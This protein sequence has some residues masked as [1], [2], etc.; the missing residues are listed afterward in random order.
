MSP[1]NS[2]R[3]LMSDFFT[4]RSRAYTMAA[5]TV[6][7]TVAA[8][9]KS[10]SITQVTD[11]DIFNV[12]DYSTPAG[13]NPLRVGVISNFTTAF[14]GGTDSYVTMSGNLADEMLASDTFDGRLTINARRSVE[15]NTEMEAVYRN[16]QR[17]RAGGRPR[18]RHYRDEHARLHRQSCGVV[19]VSRLLRDAPRRGLV[20][21]RSVLQ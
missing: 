14:D 6:M 13:A 2:N 4:A 1:L 11:P 5:V 8:G 19:H 15:I 20:F 17:A 3:S 21:W 12:A 7:A 9:C 18:R 10:D 16:M